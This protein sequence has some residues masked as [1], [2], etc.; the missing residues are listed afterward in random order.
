MCTYRNNCRH[1][2]NRSIVTVGTSLFRVNEYVQK[3]S[4]NYL[5]YT[6][7][8]SLSSA[9]RFALTWTFKP[10]PAGTQDSPNDCWS[11][12]FELK[13]EQCIGKMYVGEGLS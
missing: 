12:T 7:G 5:Q 4:A 9:S 11:A 8:N 2:S 6:G 13:P 10:T 1:N 3:S